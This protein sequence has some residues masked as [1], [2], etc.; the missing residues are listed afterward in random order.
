VEDA[1]E[2]EHE[3]DGEELINFLETKLEQIEKTL[4]ES[5]A[6]YEH[7]QNE[8]LDI[9]E[10]LGFSKEKYK[11]AALLMCEFLEDFLKN[12]P[13]ILRNP[14]PQMDSVLESDYVDFDRLSSKP[15]ETMTREERVQI[16]FLL[17]KQLQPYLSA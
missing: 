8:C 15:F 9:Q 12:K 1:E 14:L 11:R 2:G 6:E 16:V 17:L 3:L 5:Q 13:N 4:M 10:R 7:M